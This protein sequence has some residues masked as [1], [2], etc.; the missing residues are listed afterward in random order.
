MGDRK[1]KLN[2][3]PSKEKTGHRILKI[4]CIGITVLALVAVVLATT[5]ILTF[6]G[7][8]GYVFVGPGNYV[9]ILYPAPD[10]EVPE[11]FNLVGT[12][13][14]WYFGYRSV[15]WYLFSGSS[16]ELKLNTR[17]MKAGVLVDGK[18]YKASDTKGKLHIFK[19]KLKPGRHEITFKA[20]RE[21]RTIPVTVR[22]R[23]RLDFIEA[24]QPTLTEQHS[25]GKDKKSGCGLD[26]R[27][28]E[29]CLI[30][31]IG[32][33]K[34]A[35]PISEI[36]TINQKYQSRS[37]QKMIRKTGF[38]KPK[39]S[40]MEFTKCY[41][42]YAIALFELTLDAM[43]EPRNFH[44]PS[45]THELLIYASP[46]GLEILNPPR[47][48]QRK[49]ETFADLQPDG[50]I[51]WVQRRY[52]RD[53]D[54]DDAAFIWEPYTKRWQPIVDIT[55]YLPP[56]GTGSFCDLKATADLMKIS[57]KGLPISRDTECAVT[58][59][60]RLVVVTNRRYL[61]VWTGDKWQQIYVPIT[62]VKENVHSAFDCGGPVINDQNAYFFTRNVSFRSCR[63]EIGL[64]FH[65]GNPF[66]EVKSKMKTRKAVK[67]FKQKLYRLKEQI[68]TTH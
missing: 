42:G 22:Q 2:S 37:V 17:K 64:V 7:L 35:F 68:K 66:V 21:S 57:L 3:K 49:D 15:S 14:R 58:K 51:V 16:Y 38:P 43:D 45:T 12:S 11:E 31:A 18:E 25:I 27:L 56:T 24:S 55:R 65:S 44:Y 5:V 48:G 1:E 32:D 41:P 9:E 62:P 59:D 54:F 8:I 26:V 23:P 34:I 28:Q 46:G 10:C 60:D 52:T 20:G 47:T 19:L 53:I 30:V 50:R 13:S 4:S 6:L 33:K 61:F 67:V 39:K 36:Q 29:D 63:P 40:R